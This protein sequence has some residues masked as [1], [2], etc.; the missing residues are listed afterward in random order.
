MSNYQDVSVTLCSYNWFCFK[1]ILGTCYSPVQERCLL[2]P[3]SSRRQVTDH[4]TFDPPSVIDRHRQ[5][6]PIILLSNHWGQFHHDILPLYPSQ[7]RGKVPLMVELTPVIAQEKKKRI[8]L[9]SV[10]KWWRIKSGGASY[11][12][13]P[14]CRGEKGR[15]CQHTYVSYWAGP[16]LGR[17]VKVSAS[18]VNEPR[19][20][21]WWLISAKSC[22]PRLISSL[23]PPRLLCFIGWSHPVWTFSS[24]G[25]LLPLPAP[26]ISS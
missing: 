18:G 7:P 19:N 20:V 14:V 2:P 10:D 17:H 11:A 25:F 3:L 21:T 22:R 13:V 26:H 4:P 16:V 9:K 8:W 5:T 1:H 23:W 24:P 15:R 12:Y 6:W